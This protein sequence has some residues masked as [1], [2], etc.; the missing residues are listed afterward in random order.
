MA[1]LR[2]IVLASSLLAA[3][4]A[5]VDSGAPATGAPS[6]LLISIDTLRADHLGCYGYDPY[7]EPV[8]PAIDALAAEGVVF[9][10]CFAPRGQTLPS[11]CSMMVGKYPSAHGVRDNGQRFAKGQRTLAE[12]LGDLDYRTFAF[13]SRVPTKRTG[14]PARGSLLLE[15]GKTSIDG[16]PTSDQ[17]E[18][19]AAVAA[20]A[21]AWLETEWPDDE[22]PFFAWVHF[23]A[24]HKPFAPP[25]PYDT[26]FAGDYAG[27]L[28]PPAGAPTSALNRV[29]QRLDTAALE[30]EPLSAEDHAYVMALYDGGIRST[31]RHVARLLEALEERG[32]DDRTWVIVTADHGEELGQHQDYYYHGNSVY[33]P[34]LHIP[35]VMRWPGRI[36]RGARS[37]QL[38][39]NVDLVPTV[40]DAIGVEL[41]SDLEGVSFWGVLQSGSFDGPGPRSHAYFEWQDMIYGVR[42]LD[43]KYLINPNG[44]HPK[45]PPYF[46]LEG[47][48]FRISC[49]EL[50]D[51][52]VDPGETRD[53][54]GEPGVDAT[55]LRSLVLDFRARPAVVRDWRYADEDSL[56]E[57]RANGYV[58]SLPGRADLVFGAEECDDH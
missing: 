52:Q 56:A 51:L 18:S 4:S 45:K 38:T 36:P 53:L 23:Y 10:R 11:L 40:L 7:D 3:C 34:A 19:D 49:E 44:V 20:K 39:Q 27:P 47:Q 35:F 26:M 5:E 22:R 54:I 28:R 55:D 13:V 48:S 50:Y 9:E 24:V 16:E 37:A 1:V 31:D 8:S 41:P 12:M 42:T 21:L 32:L 14:H 6:I 25:P 29:V 2:S 17:N 33:D 15:D 30:R 57:L 46:G 43:R 58:G